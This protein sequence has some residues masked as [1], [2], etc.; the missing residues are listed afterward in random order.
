MMLSLGAQLL[1]RQR[2]SL[3]RLQLLTLRFS[4]QD[5]IEADLVGL[6]LA[7]RRIQPRR[8]DQLVGKDGSRRR[9]EWGAG[10]PV[11]PPERTGSHRAPARERAASERALPRS[12]RAP[13][14]PECPA[15]ALR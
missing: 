2:C 13:L 14:I 5:E 11:D 3:P 9:R 1:G 4:R 12:H 15:P 6:E 8:I 10:L 7:A